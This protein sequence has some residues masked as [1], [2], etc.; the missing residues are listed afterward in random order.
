VRVRAASPARQERARVDSGT[1]RSSTFAALQVRNYKF[2]FFGQIVSVSGTWMQSL[3]QAWLVLELTHNGTWV[4]LVTA[5]QFLPMMLAGPYGG[6]IADRVD[7]RKM[8]V[9]TQSAAGSLAL[10]L[11]LLTAFHDVRLWMVFALALGCVN[12]VDNPTRQA[13]VM[14]MVGTDMVTNAVTLNSVVINGARIVGPAIAGILIGTVGVAPC[15]LINA[16]S[17]L[18]VIFGLYL[19][20]PHELMRGQRVTRARGQLMEGLRYT[21][22]TPALRTPLLMVTVVGT[23]A[24]N[25]T[26]TLSLL[27]S[28][29]FH[30]GA[31]GFGVMTSAMGAGAVVGGLIT[32]SRS[33]PTGTRLVLVTLAF[34]LALIAC[35][36]MPVYGLELG[37]LGLMGVANI[38]FIATANTTLQLQSA[39]EMRGR[40]MALYGVAFLGTT[41]IGGPLVGWISQHAGPRF[42]LAL[43]GAA[44][45]I[46]ALVALP[47]LTPLPLPWRR[48]GPDAVPI[49][50]PEESVAA[51]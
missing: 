37:M 18:A 4:G 12:T 25:F 14:E 42:G 46:A 13:F 36:L 39:P 9:L 2:Y 1:G 31:S 27:S 6:L 17:Y 44:S 19:M 35:A 43:G 7:K 33:R 3:G 38:C 8:L 11:G 32:A 45:V 23:L 51:L 41:P 16:G 15:F 50:N 47:S 34:G 28:R 40:V 48:R 24:Y 26:V 49:P 10:V 30:A 5:A 29:T 21:W 20:R 22:R